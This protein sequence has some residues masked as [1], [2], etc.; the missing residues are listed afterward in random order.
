MTHN[1]TNID[2][3][4]LKMRNDSEEEFNCIFKVV[5]K[6]YFDWDIDVKIP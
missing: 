4:L 3:I 2:E 5:Q 6:T 1:T